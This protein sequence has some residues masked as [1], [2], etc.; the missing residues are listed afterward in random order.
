MG[1]PSG[2][3]AHGS[4]EDYIIQD[5]PKEL[6]YDFW[7]G[8]SP[9]APYFPAR[10]HWNWRWQLDFGGGQLLDWVGHHVDIAHWAPR[11]RA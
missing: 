9:Y 11:L 4:A 10:T 1:L 2:V 7:L 3:S 5:P 8:P 6:D